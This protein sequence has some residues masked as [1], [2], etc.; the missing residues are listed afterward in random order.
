MKNFGIACYGIAALVQITTGAYVSIK[1]KRKQKK[2]DRI[3][4]G[5][6]VEA[7]WHVVGAE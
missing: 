5:N 3:K 6:I 4:N 2:D 7:E 1:A